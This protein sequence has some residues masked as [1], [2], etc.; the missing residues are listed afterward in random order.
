MKSITSEYELFGFV[1]CLSSRVLCRHPSINF[2]LRWS[3]SNKILK[4]HQLFE[5]KIYVKLL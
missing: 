1:F 4:K 5:I 3:D 2:L